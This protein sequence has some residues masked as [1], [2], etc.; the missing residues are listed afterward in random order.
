M[1]FS[2]RASIIEWLGGVPIVDDHDLR[3]GER[4]RWW[5]E[6]VPLLPSDAVPQ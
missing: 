4:E 2:M 5:G 6:G 1:G 3:A